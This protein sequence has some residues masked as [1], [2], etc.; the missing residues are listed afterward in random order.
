MVQHIND[1]IIFIS[2]IFQ[3]YKI[4]HIIY[5]RDKLIRLGYHFIFVDLPDEYQR[6]AIHNYVQTLNVENLVILDHLIWKFL[7]KYDI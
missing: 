3:S 4:L 7:L 5:F 1:K 6:F 2:I